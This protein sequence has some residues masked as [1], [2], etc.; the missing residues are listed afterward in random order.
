MSNL[1][2]KT[3]CNVG[4]T[5]LIGPVHPK[6]RGRR[7]STWRSMWIETYLESKVILS[8]FFHHFIFPAT[9]DLIHS[10]KFI[11][12]KLPQKLFLNRIRIRLHCNI[13]HCIS[14]NI[15][16]DRLLNY[17]NICRLHFCFN[18]KKLCYLNLSLCVFIRTIPNQRSVQY[19]SISIH[20]M[21]TNSTHNPYQSISFAQNFEWKIAIPFQ[22]VTIKRFSRTGVTS[23]LYT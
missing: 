4:K 1:K 12:D 10:S 17:E 2:K 23:T 21:W 6:Y 22:S 20:T 16:I 18:K 7:W 19:F 15:F 5:P 13:P 11:K 3:L 9:I 14:Q 8:N